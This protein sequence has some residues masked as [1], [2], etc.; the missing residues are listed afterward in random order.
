ATGRTAFGDGNYLS[1]L[2]RIS[3]A[4][5]DL[6]G[7]PP[8]L[9]GLVERCLA[10]EP[11]ARLTT[12]AV[13]EACGGVPRFEV[14]WLPGPVAAASQARATELAALLRQPAP[15]SPAKAP[16]AS[17][18]HARRIAFAAALVLTAVVAVG[19]TFAATRS[20]HA[21]AK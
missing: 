3:E 9:R 18:R 12:A 1:V 17:G 10:K 7:C 6:T 5:P 11:E 8:Q 2:R 13:V 4:E 15:A 20:T 21:A 14:G 16:R 19:V